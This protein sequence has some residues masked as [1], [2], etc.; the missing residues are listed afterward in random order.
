MASFAVAEE[1]EALD[2]MGFLQ[3]ERSRREVQGREKRGRFGGWYERRFRKHGY[4]RE[5]IQPPRP[6][7]KLPRIT[8]GAGATQLLRD[9]M[10][11]GDRDHLASLWPFVKDALD[12]EIGADANGDGL[13]DGLISFITYDH[14]F[15]PATNCYKCSL[16]LAELRTGIRLAE[17]M[18]ESEAAAR[19][20][21]TL[22]KGMASFEDLFWNGEYYD[23]CY[24]PKEDARDEGCL[25]DQVSGNLYP[26]LCG[27]AS[28]HPEDH[29]RSALRAVHR[30]NLKPEEGLL[31]GS[32]PRGRED[33]RFFARFSQRGDDEALAGQWVTPW[34]GTEYYVA[35]LMMAEG[36]VDE[37]MDVMRNVYE[38]HDAAGMLYNHLE[39]GEHY[40][41]P[42]VAWAALPALQGLVYDAASGLARVAPRMHAGDFD[43]VFILPH[44]WGRIR[45]QQGKQ[46]LTT[47]LNVVQGA[48]KLSVL[49][50]SADSAL[51]DRVSVTAR[52]CEVKS[53]SEQ[54]DAGLRVHLQGEVVLQAGEE[55]SVR[56]G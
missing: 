32:D 45:Q 1:P 22:E 21:R 33:W 54:T 46:N 29:V 30:H 2:G 14:W 12:A 23:L 13:P 8:Y 5:D 55:L 48:M 24:D 25:A 27:L 52:G 4:S 15:L 7:R 51:T 41:R 31:N 34:T 50:L 20:Q 35:A 36:L 40:F 56:L 6:K 28:V 19:F 17:I 42:L 18:G 47:A 49:E 37:G 53:T 44:A 9:Y 11:T 10:W 3:A 38:R 26:R 39:C 43:T 16:W